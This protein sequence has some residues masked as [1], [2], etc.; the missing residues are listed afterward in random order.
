MSTRSA[1]ATTTRPP[2]AAV[3]LSVALATAMLLGA[4]PA[5][6][7]FAEHDPAGSTCVEETCGARCQQS[8]AMARRA[9]ARFLDDSAALENGY[10]ADAHCVGIPG[11]A[12]MGVHYAKPELL[13]DLR[14]E[15]RFPEILVYAERPN[16][17]MALVALEYF[18]PVLSGGAPWMGSATEPPPTIDNPAPVL[19][20]RV[21][22]GPMPGHSPTM[23]WH[24]DLH[25]WA[26][27][28]NPA[29]TFAQMNPRLRCP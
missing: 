28:P 19:F 11:V 26:W 29:G 12:A 16:G 6:A 23:P 10:V 2:L 9:T 15:P 18:V 3:A 8:L 22:D 21:F 27:E 7:Q 5:A 24:Y 1:L 13:G 20:G 17:T 25:V 14:V 4:A